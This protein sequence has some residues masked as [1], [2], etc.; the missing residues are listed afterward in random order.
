[1]RW[2][3]SM[4]LIMMHLIKFSPL[5]GHSKGQFLMFFPL[6]GHSG[7]QCLMFCRLKGLLKSHL[8]TFFFFAVNGTPEGSFS[9]FAQ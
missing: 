4:L 5:E 2:G 9:C 6:E 7:G 3:T 1:M 8:T